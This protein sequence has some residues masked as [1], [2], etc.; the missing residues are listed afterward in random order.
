MIPTEAFSVARHLIQSEEPLN[1]LKPELKAGESK[2]L[3]MKLLISL[4]KHF[5]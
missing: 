3:E 4:K 5:C 1:K 2:L